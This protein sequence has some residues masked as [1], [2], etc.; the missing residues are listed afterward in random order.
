MKDMLPWF[1]AYDH[2]NYARYGSVYDALWQH[3]QQLTQ[4]QK[5]LWLPVSYQFNGQTTRLLRLLWTWQS[6]RQ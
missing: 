3:W 4:M 2:T 1:F 5:M 6:S